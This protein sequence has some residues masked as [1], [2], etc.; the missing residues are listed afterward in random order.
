[1]NETIIWMRKQSIHRI[2][3]TF[4][5]SIRNWNSELFGLHRAIYLQ[6]MGN[7]VS[8]IFKYVKLEGSKS[9][10]VSTANAC[11]GVLL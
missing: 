11:R 3:L 4:N 6:E 1:M 10:D 5:N 8:D 9:K 2:I 7:L